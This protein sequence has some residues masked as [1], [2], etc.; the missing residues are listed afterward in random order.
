MRILQCDGKREEETKGREKEGKGGMRVQ[1]KGRKRAVIQEWQKG[2]K[3]GRKG[4]VGRKSTCMRRGRGGVGRW[5]R[6]I[7]VHMYNGRVILLPPPPHTS[8]CQI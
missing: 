4:T 2:R 3:E 6:C 1:G 8:H 7:Y 5:I